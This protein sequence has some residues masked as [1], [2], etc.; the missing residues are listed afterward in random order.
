MVGSKTREADQFGCGQ[1]WVRSSS[2]TSQINDDG[3]RL[4]E[5]PVH[6]DGNDR[7]RA[8]K[9]DRETDGIRKVWSKSCM[10][11]LQQTNFVMKALGSPSPSLKLSNLSAT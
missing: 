1:A 2:I 5:T 4:S 8:E 10:V 7:E 11:Q 6:I 3:I 9:D